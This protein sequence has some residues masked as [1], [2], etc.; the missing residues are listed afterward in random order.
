MNPG[1]TWRKNAM[2]VP[3]ILLIVLFS[4]LVFFT[5]SV[6]ADPAPPSP[7]PSFSGGLPV[8]PSGHI[9]GEHKF[10]SAAYQFIAHPG[11]LLDATLPYFRQAAS[12][13][14]S[15]VPELLSFFNQACG[16]VLSKTACWDGSPQ[17]PA[18]YTTRPPVG[19]VQYPSTAPGLPGK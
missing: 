11:M 14:R 10:F 15:A 9:P 2:S 7:P 17:N 6:H 5:E 19:S 16:A 18:P 8:A 4:S 3:K 12:L 1:V 13:V